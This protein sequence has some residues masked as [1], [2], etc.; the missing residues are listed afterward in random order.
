MLAEIPFAVFIAG[1]ALVGLWVSN[2]FYD[3]HLPQY[4]SR[5]IGHIGGGTAL[6]LCA[7]LFKSS[8]WTLILACLFTALLFSARFIKS[9]LFRGVGGT[10]RPMAFAEVWFPAASVVSIV[11]GWTWLGD[12]WLGVLPALFMAYGDAVTGLTR[13]VVYHR[14]FKGNMGSV[15]MFVVCLMLAWVFYQPFWIGA[16]G[17]LVATL[18][19]R[20][21][22]MSKGWWDDNYTIVLS[23]LLVMG[24]LTKG[25]V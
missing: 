12:R 19:E 9:D 18:V 4:L 1:V 17:A 23:S 7:L 25:V 14:E 8:L 13:S 6:L 2:I 21:T 22:P 15:A 16:V 24:I 5:K 20:F 3:F 11:A 10:G